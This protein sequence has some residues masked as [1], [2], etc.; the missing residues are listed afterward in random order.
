[1]K[2]FVEGLSLAV[3]ERIISLS[4]AKAYIGEYISEKFGVY[5]SDEQLHK[6]EKRS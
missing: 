1:M 6:I 5:F 4:L 3:K 2:D